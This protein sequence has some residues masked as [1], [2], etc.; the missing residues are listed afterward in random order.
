M[1]LNKIKKATIVTEASILDDVIS[2][3]L[4]LGAEGYTVDRVAGKGESGNRLGYD[5]S[6]MLN[7]VRIEVITSEEVAKKIAVAVESKYF[8][9]YAG[10]VYLQDVEV[11]QAVKFGISE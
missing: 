3:A 8:K 7:S 5:I 9:N 4:E 10:I 11:T 2:I 1:Q 6:G